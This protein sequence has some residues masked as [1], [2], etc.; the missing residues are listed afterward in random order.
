MA[1][2]VI[3]V[4]C[5]LVAIATLSYFG[6]YCYENSKSRQQSGNISHVKDNNDFVFKREATVT[7]DNNETPDILEEYASVYELNKSLVGWIKIDGTKVDYPVMQTV[8]NDYYLN[9]NFKQQK[10]NN[11]SIFADCECSIW[12]RS[13]NIILYGHNMRSGN[14]FGTLKSYKEESFYKEHKTINFDTI[15][16]KGEYAVMYVFSEVVHDEVEVAF[17]YYQFINANSDV[18]YESYMNE[19]AS[20][21]MYDTGVKSKYGD[22]LITLSTCDYTSGAERFVIVAKKI[23]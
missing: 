8:N 20:M 16:E 13:Q 5:M 19:M 9:H 10:D 2:K 7:L 3:S 21:S 11:G 1:R 15:Y 17:K 22:A 6:F 12:P 23:R 4:I 18:E 14:M